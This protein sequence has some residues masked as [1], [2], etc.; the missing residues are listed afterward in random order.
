MS[1]PL[2]SYNAEESDWDA[3]GKITEEKQVGLPVHGV[4]LALYV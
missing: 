4:L 1:K 3:K 2:T